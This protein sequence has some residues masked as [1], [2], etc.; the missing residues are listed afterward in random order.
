MPAPHSALLLSQS[1]YGPVLLFKYISGAGVGL[2]QEQSC[3]RCMWPVVQG[4]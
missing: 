4:H 2:L 1:M 3:S